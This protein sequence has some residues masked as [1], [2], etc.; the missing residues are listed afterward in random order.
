MPEESPQQDADWVVLGK[1]TSAYGIKG[2]IKVY[3]Y[4]EPAE[5]I[6]NYHPLWLEKNGQKKQIALESVK[7]HGKG[8]VA[9]VKG[10]DVREQ[11]PEYTGGQLVVPR[12]Q[13]AP[14]E[15]GEYY[16]SD[17]IGLTVIS[18]RGE[19]L[20]KV[21]HLIETGANDVLV[22]KGTDNSIDQRERLIPYLPDQVVLE[23]NLDAQT[24]R[25]D[26]DPDF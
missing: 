19:D 22:V 17:L 12:E 24:L 26:W 15:P 2:W 21:D 13:L 10:C 4:T 1:L 9:K 6:G 16:W 23:V 5:N 8:L 3:S 7:R 11:T 20:G 18:E 14:L 25:V